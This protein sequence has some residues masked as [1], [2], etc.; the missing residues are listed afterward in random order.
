MLKIAETSS[1]PLLSQHIRI[2][3]QPGG[4]MLSQA[5]LH[6]ILNS[7]DQDKRMSPGP[8]SIITTTSLNEPGQPS[9][10][11]MSQGSHILY[12]TTGAAGDAML[13]AI[14]YNDS[15]MIEAGFDDNSNL[16]NLDDGILAGLGNPARLNENPS[17]DAF[18]LFDGEGDSYNMDA[19]SPHN[20]LMDPTG[21]LHAVGGVS[22]SGDSNMAGK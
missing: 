22:D 4:P 9:P 14:N 11:S 10:A 5:Q 8:L 15:E 16:G 12:R 7:S 6:K 13:S 20:L 21:N 3:G 17:T 1:M 18:Q 2:E 19:L